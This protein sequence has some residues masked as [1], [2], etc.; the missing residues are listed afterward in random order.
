M[1]EMAA[2]VEPRESRAKQVMKQQY[3]KTVAEKDISVMV[4]VRIPQLT[5]KICGVLGWAI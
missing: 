3:D 4:L 2:V 5:G 1:E